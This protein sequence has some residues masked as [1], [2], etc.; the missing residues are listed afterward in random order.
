MSRITRGAIALPV[1]TLLAVLAS[2]VLSVSP[3]SAASLGNDPQH[4]RGAQPAAGHGAIADRQRHD[5][6]DNFGSRR[7]ACPPPN[8]IPAKPGR[9]TKPTTPSKPTLP[10]KS[11][12]PPVK[13]TTIPNPPPHSVDGGGTH[14]TPTRTEHLLPTKQSTAKP[15]ITPT[16]PSNP[17]TPTTPAAPS[18]TRTRPTVPHHTRS[19]SAPTQTPTA[20]TTAGANIVPAPITT[21]TLNTAPVSEVS[22]G[23]GSSSSSTSAP[24]SAATPTQSSLS[25]AGQAPPGKTTFAEAANSSSLGLGDNLLLG[26]LVAVFALAVIALVTAGGRRGS[27]RQH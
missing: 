22:L 3:A 1:G 21:P 24:A 23:G 19:P 18:H 10:G 13:H 2:I 14:L 16:R 15:T 26:A 5:Y 17:T 11:I 27:W 8:S 6:A 12:T 20:S 25:E 7:G 4:L 9:P